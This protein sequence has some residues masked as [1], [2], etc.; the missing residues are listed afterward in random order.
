MKKILIIKGADFSNV[1]VD[2]EI[3]Y[4][5]NENNTTN[6]TYVVYGSVSSVSYGLPDDNTY[7]VALVAF[8]DTNGYMPDYSVQSGAKLITTGTVQI[9][10]GALTVK[11]SWLFTDYDGTHGYAQEYG[12]ATFE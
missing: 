9:P 8:Y 3:E 11:F 12:F 1:A 4:I 5:I 2:T 10:S 7:I 6:E